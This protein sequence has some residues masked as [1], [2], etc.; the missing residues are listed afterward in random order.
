MRE[1]YD[2]YAGR[3][4]RFAY[5]QLCDHPE[6]E[7]VVQ[8]TMLAIW[9][10]AGT[11]RQASR[12]STWIFGI[13][14]NKVGEKLRRRRE[15][16]PLESLPELAAPGTP[17]TT[18]ELWQQLYRLSPEHREVLLLVFEQGFS[19]S[20]VAETLGVPLGTVKSRTF[21]ARRERCPGPGCPERPGNGTSPGPDRGRTVLAWGERPGDQPAS[22]VPAAPAP[23]RRHPGAVARNGWKYV[24]RDRRGSSPRQAT[25]HSWCPIAGLEPSYR[26]P[27]GE[28]R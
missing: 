10:S 8:E 17:A 28:S 25:S 21:H 3:L 1:L 16:Q 13:C 12:A 26:R 2:R 24:H 9:Q 6:A 15:L 18:V 4:L 5:P 22:G 20:A 19:Q 14:R 7:D 27:S 11:F 23:R